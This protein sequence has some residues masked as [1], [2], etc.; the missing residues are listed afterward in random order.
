MVAWD[1]CGFISW[2]IVASGGY[3]V[4]FKPPFLFLSG[5]FFEAVSAL[6]TTGLSLAQDL[7][8]MSY[9]HNLWH[10]MGF[11]GGQG[12]LWLF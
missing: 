7:S 5:C 9:A 2:L 11:I 10:L 3:T 12:S 6:T 4:I 8:H 1:D